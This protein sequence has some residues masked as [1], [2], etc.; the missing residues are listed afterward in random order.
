[1]TER[2]ITEDMFR[3]IMKCRPGAKVEYR[4]GV[5]FV[6]VPDYDV[7]T[8][9]EVWHLRR[10]EPANLDAEPKIKPG[11][12]LTH[13]ETGSKFDIVDPLSRLFGKKRDGKD[14]PTE[15]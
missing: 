9:T 5:K 4:D 12:T 7:N 3:H 1:M 13:T 2:T 15:S 8:D 6:N 14:T 10:V 11:D